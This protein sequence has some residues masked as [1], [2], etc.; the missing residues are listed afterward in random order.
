MT[1][2][3]LNPKSPSESPNMDAFQCKGF[4]R[5]PQVLALI[6][7]SRSAWW[8]GCKSGRYPKPIKL[9]L[10]T[11]VWKTAD[12]LALVESLSKSEGANSNS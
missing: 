2:D 7:I 5:L 10:R 12:I 1:P 3:S 9:G 11:T 4:L 8:A 6:P